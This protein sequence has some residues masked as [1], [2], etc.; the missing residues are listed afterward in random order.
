MDRRSVL[1]RKGERARFCAQHARLTWQQDLQ[2]RAVLV[3]PHRRSAEPSR[4]LRALDSY[5]SEQHDAA[6]SVWP[7][8]ILERSPEFRSLDRRWIVLENPE[9]CTRIHVA[10]L[11]D[12]QGRAPCS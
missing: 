1:R 9:P 3:G 12:E 2:R 11:G 6:C 7:A 10:E 5:E 4:W 8:G